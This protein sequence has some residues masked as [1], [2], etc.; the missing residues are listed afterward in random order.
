MTALS[1]L[2]AAL[3]TEPDEFKLW[4]AM[5]VTSFA[6]RALTEPGGLAASRNACR[7]ADAI[8]GGQFGRICE[9]FSEWLEWSVVVDE[10]ALQEL[11]DQCE[12]IRLGVTRL[13]IAGLRKGETRNLIPEFQQLMSMLDELQDQSEF[14][15]HWE[16][17]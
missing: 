5:A 1:N 13:M 11:I 2:E 10:D 12:A 9:G 7:W 8:T 17:V 4:W 14:D 16:D 6:G 3:T 15:F